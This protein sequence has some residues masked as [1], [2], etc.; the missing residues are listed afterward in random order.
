[1][2]LS[3]RP[4]QNLDHTED[5]YVHI[6]HK[7]SSAGPAHQ[8]FTVADISRTNKYADATARGNAL[9][10][11]AHE[12]PLNCYGTV[13]LVL[14][15]TYDCPAGPPLSKWMRKQYSVDRPTAAARSNQNWKAILQA[16]LSLGARIKFCCKSTP[17]GC[18][19]GGWCHDD[20]A[21][22]A[23]L[24]D[25]Q[26]INQEVAAKTEDHKKK[27]ADRKKR[28]K[29]KKPNRHHVEKGHLMWDLSQQPTIDG[30]GLKRKLRGQIRA[31]VRAM[32]AAT[33][34]TKNA[35][36]TFKKM[37]TNV[38][39]RKRSHAEATTVETGEPNPISSRAE[40]VADEE[41]C[42]FAESDGG[43]DQANESSEPAQL[44]VLTAEGYT[45]RE[46][47]TEHEANLV[48]RD[49]VT[50]AVG[51]DSEFR[52]V[53]RVHY[54][55]ETAIRQKIQLVGG[56]ER[57]ALVGWRVAQKAKYNDLGQRM[58]ISWDNV[59]TCVIQLAQGSEVWLFNLQKMRVRS[60][61]VAAAYPAQLER[62]LSSP[63][64]MKQALGIS[65]DLI[66]IFNDFGTDIENI[67]DVG[68]MA[69]VHLA[70]KF[71]KSAFQNLS[72]EVCAEEILGVSI[73]KKE[74]LSDWTSTDL[75]QA[76]IEYAGI[77]AIAPMLLYDVLAPKLEETKRRLRISIPTNWYSLKGR[78]G[79]MFR[80]DLNYWDKEVAWT[81]KD[82]YWFVGDRFQGYT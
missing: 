80:K 20:D 65:Q 50:G 47:V 35:S 52:T 33:K 44:P 70:D 42:T 67:V 9:C 13:G 22:E 12:L 1:M 18:C 73:E 82:C 75:T 79:F 28:R 68:L 54:V 81:P 53:D 21:R 46:I 16:Y 25:K 39:P 29:D 7:G 66:N 51:F 27:Q 69:K 77:D 3:A 56:N 48:L 32:K 15:T 45:V 14:R 43:R 38:V 37:L 26:V 11:A 34:I 4:A 19:C 5:L 6:L 57:T 49:I 8:R 78:C 61:D 31:P 63:D 17:N 55:E 71:P 24:T 64:I 23:Y 76:Q 58:P 10:I 60:A 2:E 74:Q 40:D 72:L 41:A 36:R 62:I 59:A 30:G